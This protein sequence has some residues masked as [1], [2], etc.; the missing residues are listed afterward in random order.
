MVKARGCSAFGAHERFLV[1]QLD[2]HLIGARHL[3]SNFGLKTVEGYIVKVRIELPN[4]ACPADCVESVLQ[5]KLFPGSAK[6][7]SSIQTSSWPKFNETF[8]FPLAPQHK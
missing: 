6:F 7:D 8:R 1:P 4:E 3:P 2:V 5:V